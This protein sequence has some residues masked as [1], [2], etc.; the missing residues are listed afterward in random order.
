MKRDGAQQK[1]LPLGE[2]EGSFQDRRQRLGLALMAVGCDAHLSRLCEWVFNVTR[3]GLQGELVKSY[4]ELAVRPWGLCCSYDKARSTVARARATRLLDV[5]EQRYVSFGQRANQYRIDWA[6]IASI[7]GL[8]GVLSAHP[9]V[10]TAQPPV[11][12]AHPPVATAHPY[13]GTPLFSLSF[14]EPVPVPEKPVPDRDEERAETEDRWLCQFAELVDARQR[15]VEPRPLGSKMRGSVF[16]PLTERC[17]RDPSFLANWHSRQ[18][19]HASPVC[20][21]TEA[22]LILVVAAGMYATRLSHGQV[23]RNRVALFCDTVLKGLWR[24]VLRY[25]PEAAEAVL[26]LQERGMATE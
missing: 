7:L 13:K 9:P 8:Q 1:R 26:A 4:K 5:T 21:S 10:A 2:A 20:G 14:Q 18:L 22:D 3:G 17:L 19:S 11:A 25:V 15:I 16:H 23:K 6:G 12:T 24:R